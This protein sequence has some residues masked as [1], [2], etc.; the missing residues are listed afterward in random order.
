MIGDGRLWSRIGAGCVTL[1]KVSLPPTSKLLSPYKNFN[2]TF[3]CHR[4]C[5]SALAEA[6]ID[7]YTDILTAFR[8]RQGVW[9]DYSVAGCGNGRFNRSIK[10]SCSAVYIISFR[11]RNK[12]GADIF[13]L[14]KLR[15]LYVKVSTLLIGSF[16]TNIILAKSP[17]RS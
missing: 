9:V 1:I 16:K 11:D 14:H 8:H 13:S 5:E 12:A 10:L 4:S 3:R 15:I 2:F 17:S 7:I 6:C